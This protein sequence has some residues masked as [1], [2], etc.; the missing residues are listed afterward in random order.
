MK[1]KNLKVL[2]VDAVQFNNN[3]PEII[4]VTKDTMDGIVENI[5]LF[6]VNTVEPFLN[7]YECEGEVLYFIEHSV[8]EYV[9]G[10]VMVC[11][12]IPRNFVYVN[13]YVPLL[14]GNVEVPLNGFGKKIHDMMA[15]FNKGKTENQ[16]GRK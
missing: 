3:F 13:I 9:T 5:R 12:G 2:A 1:T 4:P 10:R 8:S 14:V 11:E 6:M 7:E 15:D 16:L